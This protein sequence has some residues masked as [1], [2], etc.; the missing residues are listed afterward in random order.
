MTELEHRILVNALRH[1]VRQLETDYYSNHSEDRGMLDMA[2]MM[3]ESAET[4]QA[5]FLRERERQIEADRRQVLL[6]DDDLV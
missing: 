6:G 2:G 4:E 3:L 5:R 1:Y